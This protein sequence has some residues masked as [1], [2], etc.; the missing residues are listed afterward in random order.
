V[1]SARLN[2]FVAVRQGKIHPTL[3]SIIAPGRVIFNGRHLLLNPKRKEVKENVADE[4]IRYW[5][6][7]GV[8][9]SLSSYDIEPNSK[10]CHADYGWGC[11]GSIGNSEVYCNGDNQA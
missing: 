11:G 8:R 3:G 9:D 4:F 1:A 7:H 6:G 5:H 2:L 10:P